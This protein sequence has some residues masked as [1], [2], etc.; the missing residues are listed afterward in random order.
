[1]KKPRKLDDLDWMNVILTWVNMP[2]T[3]TSYL[4]D[5]AI[6]LAY[7]TARTRWGRAKAA[8]DADRVLSA[9]FEVYALL[10]LTRRLESYRGLLS[11]NISFPLTNADAFTLMTQLERDCDSGEA[12]AMDIAGT[13][14]LMLEACGAEH[15]SHDLFLPA[16]AYCRDF[17][18]WEK[19]APR[20]GANRECAR[21]S[22]CCTD[23]WDAYN[24][25]ATER[26]LLLWSLSGRWDILDRIDWRIWHCWISSKTGL[27]LD[28]C[29]WLYKN[30]EK[31]AFSCRIDE[32]KPR[33]CRLWRGCPKGKPGQSV[34][35]A[36]GRV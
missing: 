12:N 1:M 28:K 27:V 19:S 3:W 34:V 10:L 31:T 17:L 20:L 8:S 6:P 36:L 18:A 2:E 33:H 25:T 5:R 22:S 14:K 15:A 21:C 26:D 24:F 4:D 9:G 29:P 35:K 13:M 7:E 32:V 11:S 30:R 23:L 16:V